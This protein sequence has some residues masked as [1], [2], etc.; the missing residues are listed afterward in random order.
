MVSGMSG[1]A[2]TPESVSPS[3]ADLDVLRH[4]TAHVMAQAVLSLWPEARYAIGPPIEDGFYYDFDIGRPFL[5]ED[6][7]AIERRMRGIIAQDQPFVREEVKLPEALELF[8]DQPYKVEILEGIGESAEQGVEGEVVSLYRNP[9]KGAPK[10]GKDGDGYVDLC[11][12]PHLPSTGAIPAFKLLR[13]SGAY[14]RGDEHRP[15][16]QRI[17]GTA[18]FTQ[19]ELDAYLHR[20]AE[21]QRRDHRRLGV[22]LDLFSFPPELGGGLSVWHPKGGLVRR[23][24]EEYSRRVHEQS[25]YEF[26][27]SPHV[28]RSLLWE[29]SGH[30]DW[31]ADSMYPPME[32]DEQKYYVKP[33][34]CPFHTLIYRSRLRSYR[35]LPLRLFEFG[36]VYRYERS[37]VLHG[38]IRARGF[39]QDDAHIF[40][41]EE[42]VVPELRSLLGFVTRMLRDFGFDTFEAKLST[43][44]PEKSVG[45]DQ[46][47][48]LATDA[49]RQALEAE[50]IPYVVNER[51]A[52]FYGPKIDIDIRDALGRAWQLSTLQVDFNFPERFDLSYVTADNERKRPWMIHRAL[53]GS[54]ERFFGIVLEHYAGAFPTWLAPVQVVVIPIADRHQEYGEK[55]AK[56]LTDAGLRVE[57]DSSDETLGNRI[58]KAQGSKVPYML[59]VGDKEAEAG[60]VAIRG[61]SGDKRNDVALES[62]VA[63]VADEVARR[64]APALAGG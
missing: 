34:N 25:G 45:T 36:A 6:L 64:S 12:G 56:A 22:E 15:M 48:D 49:L 23:I 14:W 53:F 62:F 33:M 47:W 26:V 40:A 18:W 9:R 11:R 51:D 19:E 29:T 5:P 17:Y 2:A 21:A 27:Y 38:L 16:L 1:P 13:T 54:V 20:L 42:Q 43:R 24:M 8:R 58:R 52:A 39:T 28:A 60:T 63:E 3:P 46:G 30:L 4:S 44:D 57:T 55:V 32:L 61:R 7:E 50:G 59:V 35:E 31:Y 10:G 37:G 41:T